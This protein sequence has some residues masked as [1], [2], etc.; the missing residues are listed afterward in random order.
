MDSSV[1]SVSR[2][3]C[4]RTGARESRFALAY[5]LREE[6]F[7][8]RQSVDVPHVIPLPTLFDLRK[9]LTWFAAH[10]EISDLQ[11]KA[12][13][14][15]TVL[16]QYPIPA[17]QVEQEKAEVLQDI[18]DRMN[19]YGKRLSRAE[20]F[21]ALYAGDEEGNDRSLTIDAI[22]AHLDERL[23]FG[24]IDNDTVLY[25]ILA[26]R[27]PDVQREIRLEFD[28]RNRRGVSDFPGEE[29]DAAYQAGEDALHRAVQFLQHDAGV[30][31][32]TLLPFR[33]LLDFTGVRPG[34]YGS[35]HGGR[36]DL[37]AEVR[38]PEAIRRGVHP[39][40]RAA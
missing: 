40:L 17:Y 27:G 15:T 14:L 35:V 36:G 8:P 30:P 3:R 22:S 23:W 9:V 21:S 20:I 19:N 26:R 16:R 31:H 37:G 6:R 12:F 28:D 10:P 25:A 18:F 33:Y 1:W 5:D 29:R 39:H 32:F 38:R 4:T 2:T 24:R 11:D 34:E 7:V 13:N